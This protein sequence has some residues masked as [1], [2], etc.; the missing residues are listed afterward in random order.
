MNRHTVRAGI[1]VILLL[2]SG[3]SQPR[4]EG[5]GAALPMASD[6]ALKSLEGGDNVSLPDLRTKIT[7]VN[8]WASWCSPCHYDMP[9]LQ[10]I[11]DRF[12]ADGLSV[13]AIALDH[14]FADAKACQAE[15]Q[16]TFSMLFDGDGASKRAF[17][18][19]SVPETCI[20]GE[21]GKLVPFR[22]PKTGDVS[23][24]INDPTVWEGR[25]V[26]EFLSDLIDR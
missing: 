26:L 16:F 14:E 23:T 15:K 12:K 17:G 8:F 3:L 5:D 1:A 2:V 11:H 9:S 25:E 4:A 19:E 24:L 22:D 18:V 13:V 20:V 6:I 7:I 21:D 10:K